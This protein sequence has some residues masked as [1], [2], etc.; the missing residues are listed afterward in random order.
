[1]TDDIANAIYSVASRLETI[2]EILGKIEEKLQFLENMESS[3]KT[4]IDFHKPENVEE[5]KKLF[6][7]ELAGLLS[8]E[9]IDDYVIIKPRKY[10]GAENFAKIAR[11]V[12]DAGGD[13]VSDGKNS[14]F[15][16]PKG[17]GREK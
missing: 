15:R 6:S 17:G 14:H 5:A 16:I 4:T 13:Y 8:F 9:G 10:L 11:I 1:M 3:W 7:E 2:A 12:K